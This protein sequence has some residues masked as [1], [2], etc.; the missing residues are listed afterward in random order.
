MVVEDVHNERF[1]QSQKVPYLTDFFSSNSENC[2][3][4]RSFTRR[5]VSHFVLTTG[6]V[7]LNSSLGGSRR[8]VPSQGT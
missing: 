2:Q 1:R 6:Y 3:G 7:G 4:I 5:Q 8:S